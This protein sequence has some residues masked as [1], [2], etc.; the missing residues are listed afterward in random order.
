[1]S[2]V[3]VELRV[4]GVTFEGRQAILKKLR[5]SGTRP[6]VRLVLEPSNPY[7]AHAVRVEFLVDGTW[8]HVG[9]VPRTISKE[10]TTAIQNGDV[11]RIEVGQIAP[12]A[13]KEV[14]WA[15]I[16]LTGKR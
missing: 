10:V 9:Y 12:V 5:E 7:D 6:E 15:S 8:Q 13:S 11:E 3:T 14:L 16:V 2:E 1:V 4:A